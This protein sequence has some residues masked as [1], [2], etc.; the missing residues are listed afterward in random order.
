MTSKVFKQNLAFVVFLIMTIQIPVSEENQLQDI[1]LDRN[2]SD[3]DTLF[4]IDGYSFLNF[5]GN[6]SHYSS[7]NA[8]WSLEVTVMEGYGTELLE[9]RSLGLLGQ[10]DTII[11]NSDGWVDLEESGQFA[12]MISEARNWTDAESAGCCSFDYQPMTLSG[13]KQLTIIPPEVGPVNRTNG[14][15]GWSESANISGFS[16]ARFLRLIDLPRVGAMAEEVPLHISL[17]VGWEYKYSPMSEII[18]GNPGQ[19]TVNRSDAPVASDIRITIGENDPPVLTGARFPPSLSMISPEST[20]T[21]V[22]SCNDSPLDSPNIQWTISKGEEQASFFNNTWF[23][24]IPADLG[25]LH[26]DEI[27]VNATCYDYHG[28]TTFWNEKAL[29][30]GIDP[31]WSGNLTFGENSQS[32]IFTLPSTIDIISGSELRFEVIGSDESGLPV[33]LELYTNIS[34]GWRQ[35]GVSQQL[36]H[37]TANQGPGVNGAEFGV[38][39]RHF[40]RE[41]TEI[42]MIL[43][44]TDEAGNSVMSECTVRVLDGNPP[45]IIP[46]L[47]WNDLPIEFDDEIHEGD[48]LRLDLLHSFDDLDSIEKVSWSVSIDGKSLLLEE[49]WTLNQRIMIPELSQGHHE[50]V[51]IA[52]DSKG[53]MIQEEI[54]LTVLPKRGAHVSIIESKFSE[55]PT[56]GQEATLIVTLQN[57]GTDPAFA[58]ICLSD[59]CGRWID[60]PISAS[61]DSGPEIKIIEFNFQI[62]NETMDGISVHWDSASAGTS[63]HL[64]I[65]ISLENEEESTQ[66][67]ALLISSIVIFGSVLLFYRTFRS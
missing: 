63:G 6:I 66:T 18:H 11:G 10:I 32:G 9:N 37:F 1:K 22:A 40:Q 24:F 59:I 31:L 51:V 33:Y 19:F 7:V 48:E 52:S 50:I 5:S 23:E 60:Q 56:V 4:T 26:G 14:F 41:P 58:R 39:E 65:E 45:T 34:E 36:F 61:L 44:A 53:N 55:N 62:I 47:F 8:S 64:P 49:N 21:Y 46:R 17:P 29:I 43:I 20:S 57:E 15:W 35:Y 13:D 25:F 28:K 54:E 2:S 42:S 3:H 16:D 27:T 38:V 30:D 67:S 12:S